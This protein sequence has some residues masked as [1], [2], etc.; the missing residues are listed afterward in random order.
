MHPASRLTHLTRQLGTVVRELSNEVTFVGLE[1]FVERLPILLLA[2]VGLF[3][4]FGLEILLSLQPG[5]VSLGG[6]IVGASRHEARHCCEVVG[7]F[8]AVE[9]AKSRRCGLDAWRKIRFGPL[10]STALRPR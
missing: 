3:E 4:A 6:R 1:S 7:V 9:I 8:A 10:K 2:N 5:F